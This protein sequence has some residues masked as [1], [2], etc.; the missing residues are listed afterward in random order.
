MN[1]T[2]I[3]KNFNS[4]YGIGGRSLKISDVCMDF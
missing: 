2:E 3:V 4:S 1:I